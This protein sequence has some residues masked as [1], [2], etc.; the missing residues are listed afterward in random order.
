MTL[1]LLHDLT[2]VETLED[3][4]ETG[5]KLFYHPKARPRLVVSRYLPEDV[6]TEIKLRLVA[7]FYHVAAN[8]WNLIAPFEITEPMPPRIHERPFTYSGARGSPIRLL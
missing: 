2:L 6:R 5:G 1:Q 7:Q 3:F 4:T 8:E